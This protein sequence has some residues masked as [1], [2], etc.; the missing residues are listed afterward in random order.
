MASADRTRDHET[1]RR[2]AESRH[3]LPTIVKGTEGML[4]ID[5][6][7]G[8]A[9]GGREASLEET[10]WDKWF[11]IFDDNGL[12]FLHSPE[13]DSKFFK[14]VRANGA[15]KMAGIRRTEN[16]RRDQRDG[17]RTIVLVTKEDQGWCVEIDGE[18]RQRTY[19]N[20]ADA[21]HHGHELAHRR[22]PSELIIENVHGEEGQSINYDPSR[23][24]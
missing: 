8:K 3:G 4:R 17:D 9:S 18:D 14:L 23:R 19:P 7:Q 15:E 11:E 20:K 22:E 2:W 1:I 10:S 13:E 24:D 21:V 12:S 16:P 6:V 5:F